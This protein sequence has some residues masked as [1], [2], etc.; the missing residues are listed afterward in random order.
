MPPST[1]IDELAYV[2]PP[3]TTVDEA[4]E[5]LESINAFINSREP[6]RESDGV[7][8]FTHLYCVIT[9]RVRD[10]IQNGFF[11]DADYLTALDV[12]FANRYFNALRA[13]VQNPTQVPRSWRVLVEKRSDDRVESIQFAVA[14][15]NAHVNLDLSVAL[16]ETCEQLDIEFDEGSQRKDYLKVNQIF[17]EEMTNLRQHYENELV[18]ALDST[19][20]PV[21]D[22]VGN[23][24]VETARDASWEVAEQLWTLSRFGINRKPFVD[25]IDRLTALAGNFL[26]TPLPL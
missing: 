17:A 21:L 13:A 9:K 4:I 1:A 24:S 26:L 6:R 16:L 7:A 8:C 19:A 25:R 2:R 11:E 18:R 14:G 10:G 12:A 20:S 3:V 22:V 5:R 15:V 23:W